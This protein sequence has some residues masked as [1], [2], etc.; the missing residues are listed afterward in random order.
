MY[1]IVETDKEIVTSNGVIISPVLTLKDEYGGV[2]QIVED[3]SCYVLMLRGKD[4]TY[5]NTS[6]IFYEAW[7]ALKTLDRPDRLVYE[8]LKRSPNNIEWQKSN[9]NQLDLLAYEKEHGTIEGFTSKV[10]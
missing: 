6:Y 8:V 10:Y 7:E 3:D 1:K 2:C 5:K 9:Q 4:G